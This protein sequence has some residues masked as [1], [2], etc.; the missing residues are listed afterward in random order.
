MLQP[1]PESDEEVFFLP[2]SDDID[3][4]EGNKGDND[5]SGN[6]PNLMIHLM[7]VSLWIM[8]LLWIIQMR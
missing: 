4:D 7:I 3:L 1:P 6:H 2:D 5:D 8:M